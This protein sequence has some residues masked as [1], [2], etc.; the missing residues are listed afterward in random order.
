MDFDHFECVCMYMDKTYRER[1][2][3]Y[4][5]YRYVILSEGL[6]WEIMGH[7]ILNLFFA[8][9]KSFAFSFFKI[10]RT[11]FKV[12]AYFLISQL[13]RLSFDIIYVV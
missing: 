6:V 4:N 11:F 3:I 10:F 9:F 5:I 13:P 7:S 2:Q 12:S 8:L 1:Q